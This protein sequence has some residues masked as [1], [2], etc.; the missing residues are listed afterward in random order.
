[1]PVDSVLNR[2]S[3]DF[4]VIVDGGARNGTHE[5][6][7]LHGHS[8]IFAFE[9]NA[10]EFRKLQ[11]RPF[12]QLSAGKVFSYPVALVRQSGDTQLHITL[13]PGATSTLVPNQSVLR[14]FSR[15]HWSEMGEVVETV[16][17]PGLSLSDF[18]NQVSLPQI[19]LLKLDTQGNELDILESAGSFLQKIEV[20]K[21]EV[22]FIELYQKQPLFHDVSRYL[23]DQGFELIN[24]EWS[25]PCRRFHARPDLP[26]SS[27]RLVWGD[28]VF[29]RTP[30]DVSKPRSLHQAI[31][32]AEMGYTDLGIYLIRQANQL[33]EDEKQSLERHYANPYR[34]QITWKQK[35]KT[36]VEN[37]LHVKIERAVPKQVNSVRGLKK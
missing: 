30:Y 29:A 21:T 18:A 1:M 6:P 22:E 19:D 32:L 11:N 20:I 13:R 34:T 3:H 37:L 4:F 10:E 26:S 5:V 27:Y 23:H 36:W 35:L 31:M 24:I 2:F 7:R 15:D 17:V 9:P 14:H 12:D 16:Q 33:A 28:A 25:D 8:C